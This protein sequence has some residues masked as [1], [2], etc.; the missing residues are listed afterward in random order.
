[1]SVVISGES[2]PNERCSDKRR[3][4]EKESAAHGKGGATSLESIGTD[5]AIDGA[6]LFTAAAEE[7]CAFLF[8]PVNQK[9]FLEPKS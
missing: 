5:G 8:S 1:M 7:V 2:E 9:K 3:E 6:H 4:E